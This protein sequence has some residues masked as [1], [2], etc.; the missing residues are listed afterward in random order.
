MWRHGISRCHTWPPL[1][2]TAHGSKRYEPTLAKAVKS[3]LTSTS[4]EPHDTIYRG[5]GTCLLMLVHETATKA[6]SNI[7]ALFDEERLNEARCPLC[8]SN[9]PLRSFLW[10]GSTSAQLPSPEDVAEVVL[11]VLSQLRMNAQEVVLVFA[12]LERLV[13]WHG[14][15]LQARSARPIFLAACVLALKLTTDNDVSTRDCYEAVADCFTG[16]TP[17]FLARAEEQ[18]LE[19][20]DWRVPNDPQLYEGHARALVRAGLPPGAVLHNTSLPELYHG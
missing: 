12:I 5:A 20:L 13:E 3:M 11:P 14:A 15:V 10:D 2:A 1:G 6:P 19:L 17:L 4:T 8:D 16:L 7:P 18:L 9:A